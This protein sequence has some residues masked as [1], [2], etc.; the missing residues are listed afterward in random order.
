MKVVTISTVI[1]LVMAV[2]VIAVA[3]YFLVYI[4]NFD[5]LFLSNDQRI[6]KQ[7]ATCVLAYCAAGAGSDEVNAF[8]VMTNENI[9]S[10]QSLTNLSRSFLLKFFCLH[11]K[12]LDMNS[13]ED[14]WIWHNSILGRDMFITYYNHIIIIS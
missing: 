3:L 14:E 4:T 2:I 5:S 10:I 8:G 7:Y 9:V 6:L 12:I 13:R 11:C 1:L